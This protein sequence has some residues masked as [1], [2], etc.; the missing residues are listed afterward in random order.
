MGLKSV[1]GHAL[2][3]LGVLGIALGILSG[4]RSTWGFFEAKRIEAEYPAREKNALDGI[5]SLENGP[6]MKGSLD[7][8]YGANERKRMHRLSADIALLVKTQKAESIQGICGA[9]AA[10]VLGVSFVLV[11]KRLRGRKIKEAGG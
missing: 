7:P 1:V 4:L 10:L 8:N 11:G 5:T 6:L 9:S 3:L 2:L